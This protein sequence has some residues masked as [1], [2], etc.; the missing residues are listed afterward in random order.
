MLLLF[1][2]RSMQPDEITHAAESA[3][4]YADKQMSPADLV[5]VVTYSDTLKVALDFTADKDALKAAVNAFNSGAAEGLA[6]G[7]TPDADA[8][9]NDT[10]DA[11][12]AFTPDETEDNDF[13]ADSAHKAPH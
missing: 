10:S 2:L 3:L 12:N 9:P 7:A 8:D 1:D 13:N 4:D 5:S 6:E 11:T